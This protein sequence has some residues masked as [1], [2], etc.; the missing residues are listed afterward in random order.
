[1]LRGR[2]NILDVRVRAEHILALLSRSCRRNLTLCFHLLSTQTIVL[3]RL[4]RVGLVDCDHR[5]LDTLS[6]VARAVSAATEGASDFDDGASLVTEADAGDARDEMIGNEEGGLLEAG[7]VGGEVFTGRT[8]VAL[9]SAFAL[10]ASISK[11][12]PYSSVAGVGIARGVTDGVA[13]VVALA[14]EAFGVAMSTASAAAWAGGG[15]GFV[16]EV[17]ADAD[18]VR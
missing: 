3:D 1:V 13:V 15:A 11:S 7:E 2:G 6:F 12:S 17:V 18:A 16:G 5:G 4:P 14:P 8:T 10:G 9:T